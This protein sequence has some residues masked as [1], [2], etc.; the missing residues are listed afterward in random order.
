MEE[1]KKTEVDPTEYTNNRKEYLDEQ[2]KQGTNPYPH[3]FHRTLRNDEFVK[4][5]DP[6]CAEK[7]HFF[8]DKEEAL[9]GRVHSVR[10]QGAMLVFYDLVSDDSKVQVLMHADVYEGGDFEHLKRNVKR[11]DIIGVRGNPGRTKTGELTIKAKV[12]QA[13]S[14]CLHQLPKDKPGETHVLN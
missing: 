1:Q 14:Y 9:T 6:E 7:D 3:K 11:G 5:Y 12:V 4:K 8:T 2:R 13:L 10:E